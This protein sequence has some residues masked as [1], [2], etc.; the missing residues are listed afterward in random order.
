MGETAPQQRRKPAR[1]RLGRHKAQW[2]KTEPNPKVSQA[3]GIKNETGAK[4]NRPKQTNQNSNDRGNKKN[5]LPLVFLL[6]GA[7]LTHRRNILYFHVFSNG[8]GDFHICSVEI[9]LNDCLRAIFRTVF[10]TL[11]L[12]DFSAP[13]TPVGGAV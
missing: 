4:M 1:Q 13:D 10:V 2:D 3:I 9:N 8:S 11:A 7:L 12:V 5:G 6:T